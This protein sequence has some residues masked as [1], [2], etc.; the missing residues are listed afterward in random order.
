VRSQAVRQVDA[1]GRET[2]IDHD[3]LGRV[4][5][6]TLPKAAGEGGPPAEA[7]VYDDVARTLTITDADGHVAVTTSDREGRPVQVANGAG[8][9]KVFQYDPAGNKTL[10]SSFGDAATPRQDTAFDYTDASRLLRRT[11]PLGRVT[12][13][14]YDGVGNLAKETLRDTGG[15]SFAP[16]ISEHVYDGL[17]RRVQTTRTFE[18]GTAVLKITYD[19]ENKIQEEDPL[20]H[21]THYRY[22]EAKRL[23]ETTEP[24]WKQGKAKTTQS[25]YDGNGNVVEVRRLN[26]PANQVRHWEFD[27]LNR[28]R[29]KTDATGASWV[30]EYDAVGN[31]TREV[32][33]R[34][35]AMSFEYDA[36]N[37]MLRSSVFLNRVTTPNR[38]LVT[39]YAYDAVGN[40]LQ[41]TLPNGNVVQHRYD[42]LN[43]PIETTDRLGALMAYTYDARGNR[44]RETDARGNDTVNLYDALN[45]LIQQDLPENRTVTMTWDAAGNKLSTTDPRHNT[46]TFRYDRLNRQIEIDDPAPGSTTWT[47]TYDLA[48]NKKTET[49]RR[50]VTSPA[51]STTPSTGW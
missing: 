7:M 2:L 25:L 3:A 48:G 45:R 5:R 32:D 33:P 31:K 40:R 34:L 39:Q 17:N 47:A 11:E 27:P 22:D 8:G 44:L 1:L 28:L 10:E 51:S 49:D 6:R 46:T 4:V 18:G 9:I 29:K 50:G 12:E 24:E 14:E 23:I 30:Y 35:D 37:R 16:R 15:G 41:E 43:R 19:G 21:I 36:R 42:A 13:Y 26:E 20:G 38:Q